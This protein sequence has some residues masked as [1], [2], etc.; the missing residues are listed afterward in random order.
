[1][2]QTLL[3]KEACTIYAIAYVIV[4]CLFTHKTIQAK[5]TND[6]EE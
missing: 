6:E 2:K 1:M 3:S 5:N 4:L